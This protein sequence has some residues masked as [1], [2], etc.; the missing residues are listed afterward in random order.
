MTIPSKLDVS[1]VREAVLAE[2]LKK[3][4]KTAAEE[5]APAP[6]K[7][8]PEFKVE[9][10]EIPVAGDR[11]MYSTFFTGADK[12]IKKTGV[13]DIDIT[14]LVHKVEDWDEEHRTFIP[15]FDEHYSWPQEVLYPA[16]L[17]LKHG[18]K[19]LTVGPTGSGKTTFWQNMAAMF[20]QPFYRLGGRGD[21]ESDVILGRQ[22]MQ[23]GTME[24]LLGEFT[25]AYIAGY[26]ILLDE[27]WK[28]PS[29]I[30]MTFQ[31]VFERNG[32]LQ[33]DE[34]RGDLKDKQFYPEPRTHLVLADNV[35]GTGDGADKYGATMIQDGSTINRMDMIL[36]INYL[37]QEEEI[38]MLLSRFDFLPKGQAKKCVQVANLVR[39][40]FESGQV[41]ATMSPRNLIAWMELANDVRDYQKSFEWV[42]LSRFADQ[43]E[44]QAV[45]GFYQTAFGS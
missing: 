39:S 37:S 10:V 12:Y 4:K 17:A 16:L 1:A 44:Q 6:K 15:I 11:I 21:M 25:K 41:S 5:V 34:M 14:N 30:N 32:L 27:P 28:L 29:H 7:P 20:N 19:I 22:D 36:H 31:R 26:M 3:G 35:V 33:I 43:A 18:M 42:M 23:N 8:D 38:A 45:K 9:K 24:F 13:S 2:Y 40:G